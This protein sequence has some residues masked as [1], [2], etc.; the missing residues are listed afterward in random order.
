[1]RGSPIPDDQVGDR[2]GPQRRPSS[3][4]TPL[5]AVGFACPLG[6]ARRADGTTDRSAEALGLAETTAETSGVAVA[7]TDGAAGML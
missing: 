7:T 2:T 6:G 5:G 3:G 1:M 4:S